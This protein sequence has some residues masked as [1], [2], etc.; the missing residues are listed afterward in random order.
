M[1]NTSTIIVN[2][3][4]ETAGAYGT[5]Q[6]PALRSSGRVGFRLRLTQR[7]YGLY[8]SQVFISWMQSNI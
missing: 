8:A 6:H 1:F 7:V 3:P 5:A 4:Y 2:Y